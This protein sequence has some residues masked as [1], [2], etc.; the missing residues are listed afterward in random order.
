MTIRA[1]A[2]YPSHTDL[3]QKR[4]RL[5]NPPFPPS[6]SPSVAD[7]PP[8]R[9]EKHLAQTRSFFHLPARLLYVSHRDCVGNRIHR[10]GCGDR[11]PHTIVCLCSFPRRFAPRGNRCLLSRGEA[12]RARHCRTAGAEE[13]TGFIYASGGGGTVGVWVL[14]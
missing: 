4:K 10:F 2:F 14:F 11:A 1:P 9:N 6:W 8:C 13:T 7:S 12:F 3:L 5:P